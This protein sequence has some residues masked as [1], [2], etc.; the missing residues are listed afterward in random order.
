M[1]SELELTNVR[2]DNRTGL[3][4]SEEKSIAIPN[5]FATSCGFFSANPRGSYNGTGCGTAIDTCAALSQVAVTGNAAKTD[6]YLPT[7]QEL[8]QAYN[9]D[10][11]N[12][13]GS[14]FTTTNYFWSSTESSVDST[15]GFRIYLGGG[16]IISNRKTDGTSIR[17]VARD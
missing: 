14:T 8:L 17:C 3:Y 11:Y 7:Y 1:Q 12:K 2:K 4:W 5:Q 16:L 15:F 13:A 9:D 10:M 6:W